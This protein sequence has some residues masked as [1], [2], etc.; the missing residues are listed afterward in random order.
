LKPLRTY[1][2]LNNLASSLINPF[3]S[4]F[5]ASY[6]I[7]GVLLAIVSSAN[8]TFPGVVQFILAKIFI[9]AK[10]IIEVGEFLTGLLWLLIGSLAVFNSIF[11][12]LYVVITVCFGV[13]DFG[14]LLILDKVSETRRGRMLAYYS[15]YATVG[16]FIATLITGFI[17]RDNLYMMR[18]FFIISGLIYIIN[19][20]IISKSDVDAEYK[21]GKITLTRN[22]EIKKLFVITFIFTFIWSMAWPL[23]PLAQVY[24]FHMNELQIAIIELISGISTLSLQRV[25]GRLVDKSKRLV[26]FLGRLGLATFPLSYGLATSVYQIYLAYI[27]S[28]FTN[29]ASIS[30]TAFLFDNSSYNEKRVN[31]A[32]YNMITGISAFSGS[33]FSSFLLGVLLTKMNLIMAV[34]LMLISIGILRIISSLLYLKIKEN[35]RR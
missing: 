26:M 10:R 35:I 2:V 12:I 9:R 13:A 24:K 29:S 25:I 30:Y 1:A 14:W 23:F 6:G 27:I 34:N 3:I 5:T 4:F 11:V 33:I 17:V 8:T 16:G 20:F 18:Y 32:L 31:I 22:S 28:G 15:F 7:T 19:S 21:G